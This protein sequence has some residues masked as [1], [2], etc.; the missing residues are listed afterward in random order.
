MEKV[1]K[2]DRKKSKHTEMCLSIKRFSKSN[3][4]FFET[5][6]SSGISPETVEQQKKPITEINTK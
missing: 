2:W 5:T 1:V 6:G 4:E 3:P